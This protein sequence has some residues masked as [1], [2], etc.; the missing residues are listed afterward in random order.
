MS[1]GVNTAIIATSSK[2]QVNMFVNLTTL[3][4]LILFSILLINQFGINGAAYASIIVYVISNLFKAVYLKRV[5]DFNFVTTKFLLVV[6]L[7]ITVLI[8]GSFI[9]KTE[10]IFLNFAI[11]SVYV[12]GAFNFF[13]Y[14][15]NFSEEYTELVNS[16]LKKK[17]NK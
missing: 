10:Y 2:Y 4:L 16:L 11:R 8:T 7:V 17:F 12:L 6:L 9:P 1:T 15:M 5:F 13:I 14:K 3:V